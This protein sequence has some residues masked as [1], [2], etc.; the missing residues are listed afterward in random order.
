MDPCFGHRWLEGLPERVAWQVFK[1]GILGLLLMLLLIIVNSL[2]D[3]PS[4]GDA[5]PPREAAPTIELEPVSHETSQTVL[6]LS[7]AGL[8][9]CV[10]SGASA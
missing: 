1:V 6:G 5:G 8:P 10:R 4:A 7:A 3:S 2:G 9:T